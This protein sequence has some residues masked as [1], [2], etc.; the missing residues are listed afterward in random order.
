M[1]RHSK[2]LLFSGAAV[3]ALW[4][5]AAGGA[6]AQAISG[7]LHAQ[8][9]GSGGAPLADAAVKVTNEATGAVLNATTD[10]NGSFTLSNLPVQNNYTV[11]VSAPGYAA[12]PLAHVGVTLGTNTNLTVDMGASAAETVV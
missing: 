6:Q 2:S 1:I 5:G 9:V 7:G 8:I 4:L 12:K 10:A 11:S 3:A